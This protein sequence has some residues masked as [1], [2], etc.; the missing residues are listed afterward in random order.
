MAKQSMKQQIYQ[1]IANSQVK[2]VMAQKREQEIAQLQ[3]QFNAWNKQQ[4]EK[5]A[6]QA[7]YDEW[8]AANPIEQPTVN[9]IKAENTTAQRIP[10]LADS[11]P[12]KREQTEMEKHISE[13]TK[14]AK[15]KRLRE[16][17]QKLQQLEQIEASRR[18]EKTEKKADLEGYFRQQQEENMLA[19][20]KAN[21][22]EKWLSP[23]YKLTDKDKKAAKAYA[24]AELQK[25][26]YDSNKKPILKTP[27]ERQHYADMVSLL[28]KSNKFTNAMSGYTEL[29]NTAGTGVRDLGN[30]LV[31]QLTGLGA[32]I[33][34]KAGL[35]EGATQ[36]HNERVAE[37][38]AEREWAKQNI[39]RAHANAMTQDPEATQAGETAGQL[40]AYLLTNPAFDALSGA[41]GLGKAGSFVLNQV[42][43]NAQ[44]IV[45]DTIP[46][47]NE[48]KQ[49]GELSKEDWKEAGIGALV[50]MGGNLIIPALFSGL[51]KADSVLYKDLV[52]TMGNP[53]MLKGIDVTGAARNIPDAIRE[54]AQAQKQANEAAQN[55]ENLAKQIPEV[56]KNNI[57]SPEEL[58][59][60]EREASVM[61]GVEDISNAWKSNV[62]ETVENTAKSQPNY[63]PE[64]QEKLLSDFEEIYRGMDN[65]NRAAINSGDAKAIEKFEKLQKAV[66]D[67][68]NTIWK[69]GDPSDINKAK[70]AADAARQGFIR[71]MKKID[72]SYT[73]DLTGTK[74]G[75]AE[76]RIPKGVSDAEADELVND[77]VDT[78]MS[79]PNRFVE[80]VSKRNK[81]MAEDTGITPPEK[82]Q[83]V[84]ETFEIP[85][86]PENAPTGPKPGTTEDLWN[87]LEN[88]G[89]EQTTAPSPEIVAPRTQEINEQG[90]KLSRLHGTL[91]NTD[92]L[93]DAEKQ[94]FADKNGFWYDPDKEK[95]LAD[96]VKAEIEANGLDSIYNKYA[97]ADLDY[98]K[99]SGIDSHRLHTAAFDYSRLGTEALQNGAKDLASFYNAKARAL[100]LKA[101]EIGTAGG[102][103]NAATAYYARTPEGAVNKAYEIL[104]DQIKDFKAKN[105][106]LTDS[107]DELSNLIS[108]RLKDVDVDSIMT[109]TDEAA[110][111]DLRKQIMDGLSEYLDKS[112]NKQLKNALDGLS[113]KE[114]DQL[115]A[116]KYAKDIAKTLDMFSMG[117]FGVKQET[118][119]QVLDIFEEA[120]QYG[121]NSKQYYKL[122]KRAY[123]LLANDLMNGKS[124]KDK[125]NAWRY[126]AM[127]SNPLTHIRNN[128]GNLTNGGLV[129]IKNN[130]AAAIEAGAERA[131]KAQGKSGIQGGRTKSV[132]NLATD[133]D[134]IEAAAKDFDDEAYRIYKQGGS[135]WINVGDD[136]EA[137]AHTWK[138][139]G[140]GKVLNTLTEGNS[141]ALDV[142]DI[143]AGKAKYQTSMAGFLKAN[144]AD[145][146]IFTKTDDASKQLLDQARTYALNQANEATFHQNSKLAKYFTEHFNG[147][148]GNVVIPFKKTPA[149]ILQASFEYS[150]AMFL[151]V[152][153]ETNA[154][155]KGAITTAQYIDD[156]SK[157]LVGSVGLG[158]GAL[159]AHEGILS[160][161]SG[162]EKEDAFNKKRGQQTLALKI[163]GKYFNIGD[164]APASMPLVVGASI[165]DTAKNAKSGGDA[166]LDSILNG[167]GTI[168]NTV[169]D[170][171]MLSGLADFVSAARYAESNA[172]V[173]LSLA[174]NVVGN[175]AS[176]MLPTVGGKIEKT[177]DD[178]KRTTYTDKT[179]K[180]AKYVDQERRYL[181]TKIPFLQEIGEKM[182]K[183]DNQTI[184]KLGDKLTLEPQ[185]DGWGNE[186]KV[187]DYG[188]GIGGRAITNFV[189]PITTTTDTSDRLDEELRQIYKDNK[190]DE[191]VLKF[192]QNSSN[193]AKVGDEKMTDKQW[194]EYQKA[195]GQMK[196]DLGMSFIDSEAY[197]NMSTADKASALS[198][199][200]DF[201]KAYNQ[202]KI[203]G[204]EMSSANQK[205][206]EIYESAGGGK[207][208]AEAVANEAAAKS[209]AKDTGFSSSSNA[210]KAIQ[211]DV[212]NGDLDAA[213]EKKEAA[214]T[215]QDYGLT[216]PGPSY[217]Y[218]NAQEKIPSLTPEEFS[219]T[220]K[221]IDSNGNQGITQ[222][223]LINY[224]NNS[225]ISEAEGKKIWSAYGSS[226]WK[227]IPKL[228]DGTWKKGK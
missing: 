25:L 42:G 208:G 192:G 172:D 8:N 103:F 178:T 67:Y 121:I 129:G 27:E 134:L 206:A 15:E 116:D 58:K 1:S 68:E 47:L 48:L 62:A 216:K 29:L 142:E 99:L 223:E 96:G 169:T 181:Q 226:N 220:Y 154:W 75:N 86:T 219:K 9:Q 125:F 209:F 185:I 93:T 127:L 59:E 26:D 143:I 179:G 111:S 112:N 139:K 107:I 205:L 52:N 45:L 6:L 155:K 122:E 3:A 190:N 113:T 5:A 97:D 44:D 187:E 191:N 117:S 98:S 28:N 162:N 80:D 34:D 140:A 144:G 198:T 64:V 124:F 54:V 163:G 79:N 49:D 173:G 148:I 82:P 4:D 160:V 141:K 7:A 73:G 70:K 151:H 53:D 92:K 189:N 20:K 182:E 146:S 228:Q 126:F 215:I 40:T 164:L 137:A 14:Q 222:D 23:D 57:P 195:N 211:E 135:K 176:Q 17:E 166:A 128:L 120:Q 193:E 50:N 84:K 168:S 85:D 78:E 115:I 36:R 132:L 12:K 10:S 159:L 63:D 152:A 83:S 183:S 61:D 188:I 123:A 38:Q 11:Q 212:K 225:K 77:W 221:A 19:S 51:G 201:A 102:Q 89:K 105:P 131:A 74:L 184:A 177:I 100:E 30:N 175:L 106:K 72:P 101:R 204:K 56:P 88:A 136:I 133:K 224:L 217:T 174:E 24:Q 157:G 76:Y 16:R 213:N 153:R 13:V 71:Q 90:K 18:P 207:K 196:H 41:A 170:M 95:E 94:V 171:T 194:T 21:N 55:I 37:K 227:A 109:G 66:F 22:A 119:D 31:D 87:Q 46:T 145:A 197:K 203:A 69:N 39:K 158:I 186:M 2:Q 202:N 180:L 65:M 32:A 108:K 167:L 149:N 156:I 114:I 118:I 218:Y 199:M 110:K 138:D 35:T 150:P 60:L 165:Y 81:V 210:A 33:G 214:K 200:G 161:S 104:D 147:K 91:Q 130:L 43:Q